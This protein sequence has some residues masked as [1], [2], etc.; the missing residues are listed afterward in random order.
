M[1][2]LYDL[3]GALPQDDAEGLRAA[4][5]RAVKGAHPDIRIGDPDAP[6]RFR[7]IV[8]A[9]EILGDPEQRQAYDY[10]LELAH[11]E[12]EPASSHALAVRIHKLASGV[13][14]LSSAAVAIVGGYLLF[15][16]ISS[17]SLVSASARSLQ[18]HEFFVRHDGCANNSIADFDRAIELDPKALPAYV[19]PDFH[20]H[21][22][23]DGAFPDV[24]PASASR[25]RSA[26]TV[27]RKKSR[28]D[29]PALAHSMTAPTQDVSRQQAVAQMR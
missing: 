1:K 12:Q 16:S 14:A 6:Q 7:E 25:P 5:R 3:L 29:R 9:N 13:V 24:A 8:R 10:L 23:F 19:D 20:R 21:T 18:A 27:A 28:H 26:P 4:F 22:K 2:T 17:T 11:L 15:M